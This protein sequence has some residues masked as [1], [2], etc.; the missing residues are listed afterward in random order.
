MSECSHEWR[1]AGR[2]ESGASWDKERKL[3]RETLR[4]YCVRCGQVKKTWVPD[5]PEPES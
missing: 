2:S 5:D 4:L 3:W 1:Y